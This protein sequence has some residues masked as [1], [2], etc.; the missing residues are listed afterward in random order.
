[1]RINSFDVIFDE[2]DIQREH[3][4]KINEVL[5]DNYTNGPGEIIIHKN[6]QMNDED[7]KEIEAQ[8]PAN[9]GCM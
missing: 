7:K 4:T 8:P 2:R 1:M 9:S 6:S 3:L 5:I